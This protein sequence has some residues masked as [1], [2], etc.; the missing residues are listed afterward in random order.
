MKE[1]CHVV[2]LSREPQR[3][4]L[5]KGVSQLIRR[6]WH[7]LKRAQFRWLLY[8]YGCMDYVFESLQS[9]WCSLVQMHARIL[10]EPVCHACHYPVNGCL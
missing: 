5:C 4:G 3:L 10:S 8:L 2:I 9:C 6:G 7:Q 1:L